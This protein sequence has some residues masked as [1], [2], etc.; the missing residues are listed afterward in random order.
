RRWPM[1]V[2]AP[3]VTVSGDP[4]RLAQIIGNV[5]NNASK[6]TP[7]DGAIRLSLGVEG[8][9]AFLVVTDNGVGIPPD[10]IEAI[11]ELFVQ[12]HPSLARTEG[13]LGI[14]LTLVRHLVELHGGRI[15]ARNEPRGGA[16]LIVS[17]RRAPARRARAR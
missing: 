15:E 11:F 3:P 5:L 16:R 6:Y 10:K 2:S 17:L 4:V 14:G 13:G 1:S 12:A 7:V 9:D 8:E